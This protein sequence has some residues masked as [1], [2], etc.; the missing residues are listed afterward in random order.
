[1][2]G[3]IGEP[4]NGDMI[5]LVTKDCAPIILATT[6]SYD[7]IKSIHKS[8]ILYN[9]CLQLGDQ[10][11]HIIT[12]RRGQQTVSRMVSCYNVKVVVDDSLF[13]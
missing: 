2:S 9:G 7:F 12:T 6:K 4:Y 10:I 3:D 11:T 1:M 13:K 5:D 8:E